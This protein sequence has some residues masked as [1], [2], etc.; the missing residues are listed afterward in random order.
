MTLKIH[1]IIILILSSG[2]NGDVCN[3]LKDRTESTFANE[4]IN[5]VDA[6]DLVVAAR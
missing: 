5:Q 2:I 1:L 4:D 6:A 3:Y